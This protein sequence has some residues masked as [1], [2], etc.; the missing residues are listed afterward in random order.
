MLI[1]DIY[2]FKLFLHL[3]SEGHNFFLVLY[4]TEQAVFLRYQHKIL[5]KYALTTWT[6]SKIPCNGVVKH[7]QYV[8]TCIKVCLF[9]KT[10][11]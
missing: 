8:S 11:H 6:R 2:I 7:V 10:L 1:G 4:L 3:F 9:V 5:V